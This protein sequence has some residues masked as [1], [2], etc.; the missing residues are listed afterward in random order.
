MKADLHIHTTHSDGA[1]AVPEILEMTRRLD[2][3]AITDHDTFAGAK[4]AI[5]LSPA[6]P[7]IIYGIELSTD[8]RGESVHLLGYF[9]DP[10][11][12]GG[13]E[14]RLL[15]QR[16]NRRARADAIRDKLRKLFNIEIDFSAYEGTESITRGTI[17]SAI[18]ERG[19]PYTREEI[20]DKMIGSGR[21]AY[22]PSTKLSTPDGIELIKENGGLVF[23]AHPVLLQKIEPEEIISMGVDGIEAIYPANNKADEKKFRD[24]AREWRV[25]ISGGSDFHLLDDNMHGKVGKTTLRGKDLKNFLRALD[26]L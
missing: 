24:L 5:A 12:T 23:L 1:Y 21:P 13:V 22:I 6:R 14:E 15:E 19:Y 18:I 20:F 17:A 10:A 26:V 16:K 25:L 2:Y 11:A 7:K 3:I 4:E 9:P 8:Y